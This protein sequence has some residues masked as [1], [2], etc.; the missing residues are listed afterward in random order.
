MRLSVC[1]FLALFP[2]LAHAQTFQSS[3]APNANT[4][5]AATVTCG[6]SSTPL[7]VTGNTYLS[8]QVP[9]GAQTTCFAWGPNAVATMSPPSECFGANTLFNWGGGTGACI[10]A[11][12]TQAIVVETK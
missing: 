2:A 6:T 1:L 10:V 9:S 7:G 5:T 11:A 8:I 12:S 4:V 3:Q